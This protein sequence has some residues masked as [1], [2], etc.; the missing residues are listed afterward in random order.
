MT[1][2]TISEALFKQHCATRGIP[3]R[4]IDEDGNKV[5]DFELSLNLGLAVAEI[6]QLDPN[7]K[8]LAREAT[9]VGHLVGSG[10]APANRIRNLL[11]DAYRQIR[12]YAAQGT[13]AV[14]VCYNNAGG[15][16]FKDNFTVTR[17]MFGGMAA[18]ITLGQDG[19][20]HHTGQGFTGQRKVTRNTCRGLSAV[21]V[22]TTTPD[23]E[24][25]L[26]VYHNPYATNPLSV[27]AVRDLAD[28]QFGYNDPHSGRNVSLLAHKLEE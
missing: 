1:V 13:P 2:E 18:Y 26:V 11:S 9:P 4:R 25:K 12:P 10:H 17:A 7:A 20:I 16:N 15:L 23:G 21:C 6:K 19:L 22:L 28:S 24:T 14:V 5:A 3:C 8:D 27:S